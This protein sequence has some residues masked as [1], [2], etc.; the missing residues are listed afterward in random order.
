MKRRQFIKS[1]ASTAALVSTNAL[2]AERV[3]GAN[4]RVRVGL[5]GC[6]G[7]GMTVARLMRDVPNVEFAAVCDVYSPSAARAKEWA[8]ADCKAFKDFRQLLEQKEIDAVLVATPDHWHECPTVI[9]CP[10]GNDV[11]VRK[12]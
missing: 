10:V 9:V 11:S 4:D 3:L 2:S 7:R 12:G 6:G 1:V 5:I 8:G